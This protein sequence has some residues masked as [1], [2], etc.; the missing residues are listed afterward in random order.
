M[1]RAGR[2]S[3]ELRASGRTGEWRD[4]RSKCPKVA[5]LTTKCTIIRIIP[6]P[7]GISDD[8][9][10][11]SQSESAFAGYSWNLQFLITAH[12]VI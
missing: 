2:A 6:F 1:E 9:N 5:C 8:K 3:Y 12:F 7:T 10:N 11:V 4:T